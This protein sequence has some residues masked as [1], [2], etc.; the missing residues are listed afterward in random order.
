MFD[1]FNLILL[2]PASIDK[3]ARRGLKCISAIIGTFEY[4]T[5]FSTDSILFLSGT[6]T[7]IKSAPSSIIKSISS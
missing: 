6:A 1:G 3:I 7:L 5:I 2:T 4:L